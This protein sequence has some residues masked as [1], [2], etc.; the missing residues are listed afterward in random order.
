MLVVG[1]QQS[2]VPVRVLHP[3]ELRYSLTPRI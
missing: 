3:M 2:C 1:A